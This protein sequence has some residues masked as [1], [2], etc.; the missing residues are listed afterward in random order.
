MKIGVLGSTSPLVSIHLQRLIAE[1][2]PA[3][4]D[5]DHLEVVSYTNPKVADYENGVEKVEDREY[6]ETLVTSAQLLVR[7]GVSM[8]A[9]PCNKAHTRISDIQGRVPVPVTNMVELTVR[10]VLEDHGKT[11]VG[12][13]APAP[14]SKIY[15]ET[16]PGSGIH[17]IAPTVA[18]QE[19]VIKVINAIKAGGEADTAAITKVAKELIEKGAKVLV[20]GCAK[21]SVVADE[22]EKL[23]KPVVDPM[24][25]LAEHLVDQARVI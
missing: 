12:L 2:T 10:R 24:R 16:V 25:V 9:I 18:G 19:S 14:T 5:Q 4:K 22:V 23:G 20:L 7:A 15:E 17:W 13:I 1:S 3:R 8:I 11:T 6:H 21:L